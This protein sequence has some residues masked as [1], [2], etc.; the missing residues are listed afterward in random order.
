[1]LSTQKKTTGKRACSHKKLSVNFECFFS[2]EKVTWNKSFFNLIYTHNDIALSFTIIR[3][4]LIF[5]ALSWKSDVSVS[6]WINLLYMQTICMFRF[7]CNEHLAHAHCSDSHIN[8]H[9][10]VLIQHP[11]HCLPL[12]INNSNYIW[13]LQMSLSFSPLTIFFHHRQLRHCHLFPVCFLLPIHI[14]TCTRVISSTLFI[15]IYSY[16]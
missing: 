16:K 13:T 8:V 6:W 5:S 10:F 1:M 7:H 4:F 14:H 2:V 3:H 11:A 12:A 9:D 15:Y